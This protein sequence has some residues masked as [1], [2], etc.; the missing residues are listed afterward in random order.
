[1]SVTVLAPI[2]AETPD[3]HSHEDALLGM[4][5]SADWKA[6]EQDF[7]ARLS[8]LHMARFQIIEHLIPGM[9]NRVKR[10]DHLHNKYLLF[11]AEIDGEPYDFYD[12][13]YRADFPEVMGS[14]QSAN[15]GEYVSKIWSHCAGFPA[16][17]GRIY[18]FRQFMQRYEVES[19]LPYK[20][21]SASKKEILLAL[22]IKQMTR[23]WNDEM[24]LIPRNAAS[25]NGRQQFLES[26]IAAVELLESLDYVGVQYFHGLVFNPDPNII[27]PNFSTVFSL[28][29][30]Y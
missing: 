29:R 9:G 11:V 7:L 23:M 6:F 18:Q 12:A 4:F 5:E 8:V 2:L 15:A 25:G 14:P 28:L 3:D 21:V 10:P 17:R 27:P 22:T 24:Q 20:G 16:P 1:M 30:S 13:M 26:Y 19:L